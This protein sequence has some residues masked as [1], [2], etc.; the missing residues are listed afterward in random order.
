V[1]L[2][3]SRLMRSSFRFHDRLYRFGGEEFV[4]LMRWRRNAHAGHAGVRAPA[5]Q[6]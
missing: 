2:L 5:F 1:L 4:V 6:R 3:L